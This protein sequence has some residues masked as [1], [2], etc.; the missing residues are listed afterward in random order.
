MCFRSDLRCFPHGRTGRKWLADPRARDQACIGRGRSCT[1]GLNSSCQPRCQG[2]HS[3]PRDVMEGLAT[4]Q[5]ARRTKGLA[6]TCHAIPRTSGVPSTP[7]R[8]RCEAPT[9]SFAAVGLSPPLSIFSSVISRLVASSSTQVPRPST[10]FL[11][12][13]PSAPRS[14]W[15]Q[16]RLKPQ[17]QSTRA[18]RG[19]Q[20]RTQTYND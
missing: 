10:L 17:T 1:L 8:P 15:G 3:H 7:L 13:S 19:Q 20:P 12:P 18:T 6:Q 9:H 16:R 14:L 11:S 5:R 2:I 4:N